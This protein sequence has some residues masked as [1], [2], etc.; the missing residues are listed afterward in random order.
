MLKDSSVVEGLN[1]EQ[2]WVF[3]E[4]LITPQYVENQNFVRHFHRK[5]RPER[6][7]ADREMVHGF[8]LTDIDLTKK[9]IG[10]IFSQLKK[11]GLIDKKAYGIS[12]HIDA[13]LGRNWVWI[14][15]VKPMY[16]PQ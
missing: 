10:K 16:K 9:E 11:L 3:D 1:E 14:W 8:R 12:D 6:K 13:C 7:V 2:R 4:C 15:S 5:Y